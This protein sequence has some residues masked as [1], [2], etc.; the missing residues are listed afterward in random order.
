MK[1]I[2]R[3]GVGRCFKTRILGQ[4]HGRPTEES[5]Y[6]ENPCIEKALLRMKMLICASYDDVKSR[7]QRGQRSFAS[8]NGL[9]GEVDFNGS[10]PG[11]FRVFREKK[12]DRLLA[13][14]PKWT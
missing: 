5:R 3:D 4:P 10:L 6:I 12:G 8:F 14:A 2:D 9:V 7:A 13:K 11:F 1:G